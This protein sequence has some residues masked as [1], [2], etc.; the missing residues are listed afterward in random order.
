MLQLGL[1]QLQCTTIPYVYVGNM[2]GDVIKFHP[3]QRDTDRYY[4]SLDKA[5]SLSI[6]V[7]ALKDKRIRVPWFEP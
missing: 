2:I 4:Y 7:Q 1:Q 6:M 5:R 3:A